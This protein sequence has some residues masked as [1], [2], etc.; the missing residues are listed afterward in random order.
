MIKPNWKIRFSR[1]A[2][3][4][5]KIPDLFLSAKTWGA[6]RGQKKGTATYVTNSKFWVRYF[7]RLLPEMIP[8]RYLNFLGRILARRS[9]LT[10]ILF[11]FLRIRCPFLTPLW[12][13]MPPWT[14]QKSKAKHQWV[15]THNS[16]IS[17]NLSTLGGVRDFANTPVIPRCHLVGYV[18]CS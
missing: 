13:L 4:A 7:S 2:Q 16:V 3:Y 18:L 14:S 12:L 11:S 5:A 15:A 1:A 6:T 17:L 10:T 8:P 9:L